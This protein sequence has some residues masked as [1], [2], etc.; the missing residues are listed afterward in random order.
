MRRPVVA[1]AGSAAVLLALAAPVL[2]METKN[3]ALDQFPRDHE[4]VRGFEA[5]ARSPAPGAAS[6]VHVVVEAREGGSVDGAAGRLRAALEREA[7]VAGVAE[8][9]PSRDGSAVLLV[10]QTRD[11]PESDAAKATVERL[12]ARCRAPAAPARGSTSA[13]SPRRRPT[14]TT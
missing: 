7:G 11:D 14:S 5:A 1:A 4:V 2:G 13:A 3:G 6:P 9:V 8:P 10:A 12:R